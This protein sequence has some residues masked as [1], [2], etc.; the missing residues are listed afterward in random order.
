MLQLVRQRHRRKLRR[1][2]NLIRIRIAHPANQP[3]IGQ[4]P[5]QRAILLRQRRSKPLQIAR[6]NLNPPGSIA[7]KPSSP[8]TTCNDARR[9]VPASVSTSDPFAKSKAAKL[10]LPASRAPAAFQCNRPAI[11]RCNTSHKSPST[12]IA[13]RFPIRRTPRTTRPSTSPIP[14]ST[15]RNKKALPN[16]TRSSGC[17]T[18]RGSSALMYAE[19]SGSSGMRNSMPPRRRSRNVGFQV[20]TSSCSPSSKPKP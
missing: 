11:I 20:R 8:A 10:C 1:M 18:M 19:M 13:I 9:F 15:V 4:R 16:R 17:P 7:R 5:L 12:P 3:R 6:K 14:G 2:Q